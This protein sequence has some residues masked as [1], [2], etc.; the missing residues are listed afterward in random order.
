MDNAIAHV[1]HPEV[2]RISAE[3]DVSKPLRHSFW[4]G[5]SRVREESFSGSYFQNNP[6]VLFAL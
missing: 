5:T 6:N 4:L 1:T 2:A 3:M